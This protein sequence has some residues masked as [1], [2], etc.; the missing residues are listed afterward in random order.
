MDISHIRPDRHAIQIGNT[1]GK[2][3]TLNTGMDSFYRGFLVKEFLICGQNG[4]LH[5]RMRVVC[6]TGVIT[7]RCGRAASQLDDSGDLLNDPFLLR[8]D[9]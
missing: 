6:P 8:R 9:M 7:I 3:A 4:V 2:Q 5:N 1:V